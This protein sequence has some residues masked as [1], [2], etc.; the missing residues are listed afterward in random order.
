VLPPKALAA[1]Q[2]AATISGTHG[3]S[4]YLEGGYVRDCLLKIPDYDI[5]VSVVGDG[6]QLARLLSTVVGAQLEL[7]EAFGTAILTFPGEPFHIDIV[8]AR[9]ERYDRP[10]ALPIITPSGIEDDLARRDFTINAMAIAVHPTGFGPLLDPH[11]GIPDLQAGLIRVLHANSFLDDPTRIFR[12]VRFAKRLDFKIEQD[13]LELILQAVRDNA[14]ST[15]SIDRITHELLLIMEEPRA[16]SML[17]ELEKLGVLPAIHP[18]LTWPYPDAAMGPSDPGSLTRHERR[19]TYLAILASE[20]ASDPADAESLARWL[21]L[22]TP[23]VRIMRDAARLTALWP[24][25]GADDLKPSQLYA[26]LHPLD[27][28]SLQAFARITPLSADNVPWS[29]LHDY[30]NRLKS[31]KPALN[32]RYLQQ[33]GIPPGPV[34]KALLADLLNAKL[35]GSLPTYQDEEQF[36]QSWLASHPNP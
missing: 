21:H 34:Y 3:W 26:L 11:G 36:V 24:A 5:D 8:T 9:R 32:G 27:P 19:D 1:L 6:S 35:D 33:Q 17:A 12:A 7:H 16:G 23:Q 13:T 22:P 14:L 4:L 20:F 18:A 25:L 15:V 31:I 30:L 28:A 10:G 2:A 29:R